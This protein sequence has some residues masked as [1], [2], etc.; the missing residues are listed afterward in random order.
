MMT[1]ASGH[2]RVALKCRFLRA[3]DNWS[4]DDYASARGLA[5]A[6]CDM[7][8]VWKKGNGSDL[9]RLQAR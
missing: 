8:T 1:S 5:G 4:R 3:C 9:H 2:T 7:V 6:L